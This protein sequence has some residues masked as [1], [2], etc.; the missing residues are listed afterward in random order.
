VAH[1]RKRSSTT[2]SENIFR[3]LTSC[4]LEAFDF[5]VVAILLLGQTNLQRSTVK[6]LSVANWMKNTH[7]DL[8]RLQ[9][10]TSNANGF[11]IRIFDVE[12]ALLLAAFAWAIDDL[13]DALQSNAVL[14]RCGH[15]FRFDHH[16]RIPTW[17]QRFEVLLQLI[18]RIVKVEKCHVVLSSL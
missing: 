6:L 9:F 3:V 11:R 15:Q 14:V 7:A 12:T 10:A 16:C 8:H 13:E 2:G 5:V 18:L 1:R 17:R 4:R